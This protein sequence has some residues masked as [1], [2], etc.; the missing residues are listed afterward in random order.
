MIGKLLELLTGKD[1]LERVAGRGDMDRLKAYLKTR[2]VFIARR[3]KRFLDPGELT[4]EALLEQIRTDTEEAQSGDFEPWIL[5]LDGRRRLPAFTSLKRAETF[6]GRICKELGK[7]FGVA[8][9]ELL[10][11][12]ITRQGGI[13]VVD[14]NLFCGRS[15]EIEIR[16]PAEA[17]A[18]A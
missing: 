17:K 13:D 12:D 8:Y 4:R 6:T 15:W 3:P 1:D 10:L 18:E 16:E 7:V 2:T 14:L 9:A 5:E 11:F